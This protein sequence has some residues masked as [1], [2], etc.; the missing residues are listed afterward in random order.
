MTAPLSTELRDIAQREIAWAIGRQAWTT[1][2]A[3]QNR[4]ALQ[5][6]ELRKRCDRYL[7]ELLT[8]QWERADSVAAAPRPLNE[9]IHLFALEAFIARQGE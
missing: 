6:D 7:D 5:P 9:F 2:K 1:A 4:T 3:G 8:F